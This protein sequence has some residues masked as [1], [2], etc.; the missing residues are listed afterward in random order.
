MSYAHLCRVFRGR[1]GLSPIGYV[2][3]SRIERARMFL[4]QGDTSV[5]E[6]SRRLG[7][8]D[9]AYFSRLFRKYQGCAPR[10]W[11]REGG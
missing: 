3:A 4:A 1:Y 5:K 7:F 6:V 2:N 10:T 9:P 8:R 11:L